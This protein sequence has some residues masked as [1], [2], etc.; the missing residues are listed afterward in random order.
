MIYNIKNKIRSLSH[1]NTLMKKLY[2]LA[3]R[4]KVS[5]LSRLSDETFAKIKYKENTGKTLDLKNPTTFNEKLWWLKLNNRDPLLTICSDKYKVRE[6]VKQCGLEHILTK[7]YGVYDNANDIDFDKLPDRAFI[8]TNHGSGTNIIWDR[9][10]PFNIQKFRRK[11]N[12]ALKRNYFWQSREWNYKNIEPKIIVEEVLEDKDG[13]LP[14]DYKFLCFDGDPR[15]L[16][17][18]ENVCTK[19]GEHNNS[20]DRYTNVYDMNYKLLPITIK[21]RN[22]KKTKVK[23]PNNFKKMIDCAKILSSP[24]PH[25]RIDLYNI[26][27]KIYFGEI[28]F[29]HGGA[30]H[31]IEPLTWDKKMGDWIDLNSD[32]IILK[33]K[34]N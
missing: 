33:S 12:N 28:T 25:C 4:V 15:L 10:K 32:K 9:N 27:G 17:V 3:N 16:L 31:N 22:D 2:I 30:C 34:Q 7:L 20:D 23:K 8:K 19:T 18:S 6:Y 5:L 21:F 29:Y 26:D 1:R 11:F 14:I 24:F 13:N